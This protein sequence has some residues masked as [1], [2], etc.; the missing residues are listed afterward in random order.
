MEGGD[1]RSL[2]G[3]ELGLLTKLCDL[4]R[5]ERVNWMEGCGCRDRDEIG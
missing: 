4:G 2:Q 3:L 1:S 5:E